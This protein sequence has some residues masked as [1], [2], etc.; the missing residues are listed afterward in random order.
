MADDDINIESRLINFVMQP[1]TISAGVM[2]R[3]LKSAS[4]CRRFYAG[5]SHYSF[6]GECKQIL[7]L[8]GDS[9]KLLR[10]GLSINIRASEIKQFKRSGLVE[11]ENFRC[12]NMFSVIAH[13]LKHRCGSMTWHTWGAPGLTAGVLHDDPSKQQASV[14]FLR[15]LDLVL[16]RAKNSGFPVVQAMAAPQGLESPLMRWLRKAARVSDSGALPRVAV[17]MLQTFWGFMLNDK[18]IEDSLKLMREAGTRD[19]TTH[20]CAG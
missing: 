8:L 3:D 14:D 20:T 10:L 4:S 9:N 18:F 16:V 7:A 17:E 13:Q 11:W 1:E 6:L 15:K 2:L 5:W 12:A 19:D